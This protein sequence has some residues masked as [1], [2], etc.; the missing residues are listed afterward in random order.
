MY[1]FE[2]IQRFVKL[3]GRYAKKPQTTVKQNCMLVFF[4]KDVGMIVNFSV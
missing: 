1:V 3:Q 4:W 2:S